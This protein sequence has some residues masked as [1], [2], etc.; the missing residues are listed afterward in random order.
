M[1]F[2]ES[3][4]EA[5][6]RYNEDGFFVEPDV[7]PEA[8]CDELIAAALAQESAKD[9][10]LFPIMQIHKVE[11]RFLEFMANPRIVAM[12]DLVCGGPVV[13]IQS[14]F[15]FTPPNRAGLGRHQDNYFV[16]APDASFASAWVPLVDVGPD[17]GGLYAFKGSHKKGKLPVRPVNVEGKDKRQTVYEETELSESLPL[18][19][20]VAKRGSVVL[21]HGFNVHGSYPNQTSGN[22]YVILNT[23]VREGA[24]FRAGRTARREE[25]R[26]ARV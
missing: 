21:I 24:P 19:D 8:L 4:R 15:Y 17:N 22:R 7:V 25:V 10:S 14:Q 3:P 2:A 1:T 23:Y 18:V 9:G 16:E 6:L 11:P 12:M 20:I 13:G 26:L 5:L